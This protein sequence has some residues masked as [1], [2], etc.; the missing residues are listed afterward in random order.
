MPIAARYFKEYQE[1]F[2]KGLLTCF[3]DI[4]VKWEKQ[5][6]KIWIKFSQDIT[7]CKENSGESDIY[8]S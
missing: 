5:L 6:L 1:H 3:Y 4:G 2:V 8:K 7:T